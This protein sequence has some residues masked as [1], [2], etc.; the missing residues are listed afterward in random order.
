MGHTRMTVDLP[1]DWKVKGSIQ[2]TAQG[3]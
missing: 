3:D 1:E 2:I